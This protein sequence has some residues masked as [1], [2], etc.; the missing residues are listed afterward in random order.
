MRSVILQEW[1][2]LD[3]LAAGPEGSVDFI[4]AASQ[5]DESFGRAQSALLDAVDTIVL[6]RATYQMFAGYWPKVTEGDE[7]PFA[8]KL[9]ATPKVVFSKT[10]ERAPWG[11]WDDA[12]IVTRAP[13]DEL[14][15]LKRQP[16][17]DIVVWGSISL[18]QALIAAGA[19]DEYRI[20]IC[21]VLLGGGRPL[22]RDAVPPAG[23]TLGG[24]T[25]FDRGAVSLRYRAQ[26]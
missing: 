12:R 10:L 20:V 26:R 16:G 5:G 4:P 1:V 14:A 17:K 3:G 24:V 2:S 11:A 13:A 19:I 21:P 6:G 9:N 22:F 15:E 25:T 18:A 7:R 23:L 8:D